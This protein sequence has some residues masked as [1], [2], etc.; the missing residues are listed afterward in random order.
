MKMERKSPGVG[1]N[2][3]NVNVDENDEDN[4]GGRH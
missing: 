2:V 1:N 4:N 3:D